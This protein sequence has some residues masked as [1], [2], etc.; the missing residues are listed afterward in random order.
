MCNYGPFFFQ[1]LYETVHFYNPPLFFL[2]S[3]LSL[4]F[5]KCDCKRNC[6]TFDMYLCIEH[7]AAFSKYNCTMGITGLVQLHTIMK[8][9]S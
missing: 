3:T 1:A 5:A 4:Y 2:Q 7:H 9:L 6:C 8:I